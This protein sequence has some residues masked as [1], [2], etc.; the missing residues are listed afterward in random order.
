MKY[1]IPLF[2]FTISITIEIT[3]AKSYKSYSSRSAT[4]EYRSHVTSSKK[5]YC[6]SCK[7]DTSG[8][9]ERS[10]SSRY[11]FLKQT[12]YPKGR[13]GYVVDHI[14]PLKRG[15]MDSPSNMQWQTKEDALLK[16]KYE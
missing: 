13:K 11:Q 1:L 2:L 6:D 7:R 14:T 15:G 8:R 5:S 12:G 9:I 3:E 10:S 16:D 4:G